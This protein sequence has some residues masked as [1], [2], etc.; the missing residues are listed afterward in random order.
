MSG[1]CAFKMAPLN[2]SGCGEWEWQQIRDGDHREKPAGLELQKI[3][4]DVMS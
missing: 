1:M 2:G 4:D 3:K